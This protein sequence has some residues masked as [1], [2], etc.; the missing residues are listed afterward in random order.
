[1]VNV[2]QKLFKLNLGASGGGLSQEEWTLAKQ[3][4]NNPD[5]ILTVPSNSPEIVLK[6]EN[7]YLAKYDE[8][9]ADRA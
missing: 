3:A 4:A 7:D 2:L 8:I 1:M 9:V 6:R 5:L